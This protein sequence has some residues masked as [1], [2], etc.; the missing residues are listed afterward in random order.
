[1]EDVNATVNLDF[2]TE[3]GL[4]DIEVDLI[5]ADYL[6]LVNVTVTWIQTDKSECAQLP[7]FDAATFSPYAPYFRG[8]FG[9]ADLQLSRIV[10]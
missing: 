8:T 5:F 6:V 2:S 9:T 1:M 4:Q 10:F 7:A 3:K